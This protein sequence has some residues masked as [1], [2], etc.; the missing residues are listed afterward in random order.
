MTPRVAAGF[1]LRYQLCLCL[2]GLLLAGGVETML[3]NLGLTV[4]GL[5]I[6]NYYGQ[7]IFV[8]RKVICVSYVFFHV[9]FKYVTQIALSLTVS[10]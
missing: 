10:M 4:L 6:F 8:T 5:R 9:K 1:N 3:I 7:L 2:C